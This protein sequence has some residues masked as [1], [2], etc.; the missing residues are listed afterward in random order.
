M[1]YM[2][3]KVNRVPQCA[4]ESSRIKYTP[5]EFEDLS[6]EEMI[7]K[8]DGWYMM[9]DDHSVWQNG[10]REESIINKRVAE[11]GGWTKELIKLWN[12]SYNP[13]K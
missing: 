13:P 5:V 12:E 8:H 4:T 6:L 1:N 3:R 10:V 2:K 7:I 11:Q 9:S